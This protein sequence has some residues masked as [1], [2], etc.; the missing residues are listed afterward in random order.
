VAEIDTDSMRQFAAKLQAE[1][2]R[3]STVNRSLS[4]LRRM[5][6]LAKREGK[7]SELPFVP[8]LKEPAPRQ[9]FFEP[10]Q[11]EALRGALPE[12]LR[13]PLAVGYYTA[14]RLGEILSLEWSQVDFLANTITLHAGTTKNDEAR[15]IPLVP[16]LRALLLDQRA[17]RQVDCPYVCFRLD[18]KGHA[19]QIQGFRKSW[20]RACVKVGLGTMQ[21]A[22]DRATGKAKPKLVYQGMIFHDLR[23]SGVR[24]L[25]RAGVPERVAMAISGH[26]TRAIFD[27]YNITSGNDLSEAGRKLDTYLVAQ[28]NGASSGQISTGNEEAKSVHDVVN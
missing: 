15:T 19:L 22:I 28:K 7:I 2:K 12:H 3:D 9:G 10:D 11:F 21:P 1:G 13:L 6:H 25:V 18:A 24:N 27:R 20:Y 23:R 17:R 5:L 4:V 16:Q 26:K 14:M 8:M